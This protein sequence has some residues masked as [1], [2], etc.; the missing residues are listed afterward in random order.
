MKIISENNFQKWL[1]F[2]GGIAFFLSLLKNVFLGHHP[3]AVYYVVEFLAFLFF[4]G[5]IFFSDKTHSYLRKRISEM[6]QLLEEERAGHENKVKE[7]QNTIARYEEKENEAARIASY[8]DKVMGKLTSDEKVY[9]DKHHLLYLLAEIFHGMAVILYKKDEPSNQF[10]VEATYGLTDDFKP[11]PFQAGEGIHG[12]VV[13]DRKPEL[14]EEVPEDYVEVETALGNSRNYYLYMLPIIQNNVCT[15]MIE[16]LT[17]RESDAE[18]IWPEVMNKLV[19]K[20]I[21]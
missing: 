9:Q 20:E 2:L 11:Q 4:L 12:Q 8:Q 10:V 3:G 16:M 17:F 6:Q 14:V 5:A 7:L 19:E 21:L 15:G 13:N 18:R 1:F